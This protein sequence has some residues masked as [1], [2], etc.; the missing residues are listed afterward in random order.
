[1]AD[2]STYL[3]QILAATYGE[4]VRGSI[5]D[6]IDIIN[7][8]GEKVLTLGTAVD[9]PTS[10]S[11]GFYLNS[12]YLNTTTFELWKNTGTNAWQS[13]GVIKGADG[14]DGQDGA[15]GNGIVSITKTGTSGLID[16]YTITF[17]D[18]TT[19]NYNVSNG[20]DGENG[21]KW[22]RGTGITGTSTNPTKFT[23][24]GVTYAYV[25]DNYLN[26]STGGVY[27]CATEG[28]PNTA[29][30][31][32]DFAMSGGG[33][34]VTVVDNL[35][36][37]SASDALS[38]NQGYVL[39]GLVDTKA[40]SSDVTTGLAGKVD[41]VTGKGLSKNDYTDA[42]KAIV[43]G[44][45]S[46]LASKIA[47]PSTKQTDDVLTFNGTNWV[48]QAPSGGGHEIIKTVAGVEAVTSPSDEHVVS[49]Y[50]IKQY[51]NRFTQRV[52]STLEA[53]ENQITITS[54]VFKNDDGTFEFLFEPNGTD[55][56]P[57][58]L[59]NYTLNTTTGVLTMTYEKAPT[60]DTTVAVD[61]S[62]YRDDGLS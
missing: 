21:N 3:N 6:S 34:S 16:T 22:Y 2:I 15:Q 59:S 9:S 36:S 25:N 53:D 58:A 32:Y 20:A 19:Q 47:N 55:T 60:V 31:V 18:G 38:A 50:T 45:T 29:L 42:D 35:T 39:K 43:D 40:S 49:A 13:Q 8:V 52:L 57:L 11:T 46:A 4:E 41:K 12:L 17:D 1:M 61:V 44:V 30:W 28:N 24:S 10:S 23:G 51:S 5:H 54:D 62:V 7:K 33:S 27:H 14:A 37:Q 56:Y 26:V 48:A